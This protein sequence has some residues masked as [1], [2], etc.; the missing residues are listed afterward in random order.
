MDFDPT[1]AIEKCDTYSFDKVYS[2]VEKLLSLCPPPEV[3]GKTVLIKPNMLSPKKPEAAVCTN[4]AVVGAVVKAFVARG[5]QV[6]VGESPAT[7]NSTTAAKTVGT[8][9]AVVINGGVWDAFDDSV[10]VACPKGK[11]VKSFEFARPFL[12]ADVIVSVAKLKTHQLMAY[13][14]AMKNLFGLMVGLKKAQMHF[15]F[16]QRE[17]FSEFLV[18]LNVAAHAQYSIMDA[19]VGME[20]NG[21]PGNGEPKQLGFL[22]ASNNILA[23]DWTCAS[24]VGYKPHKVLYLEAALKRGVWLTNE[25]EIKTVGV[26][27]Q[28]VKPVSF[29]T[30]ADSTSLRQAQLIPQWLYDVV[31]PVM[32][33]SPKFLPNICINCGKCIEICPAGILSFIPYKNKKRVVIKRT[34]CLHCFCCH[35]I[36]PVEAIKLRH[37]VW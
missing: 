25:N 20:G 18:D 5:A 26:S 19:I 24:I 27:P 7:A 16:P 22:A 11:L 3:N 32:R 36:C 31:V 9:D 8:Y 15:R 28:S 21:G 33:R 10:I 6:L 35:E 13:T 17:D 30:V 1:V 29:K 23:L 14:G 4:P 2:A 12:K 34:Q 37:F